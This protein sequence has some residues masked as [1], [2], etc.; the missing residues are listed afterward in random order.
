VPE[1]EIS[2]LNGIAIADGAAKH[3]IATAKLKT[4]NTFFI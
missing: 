4:I 3:I 2:P 1:N